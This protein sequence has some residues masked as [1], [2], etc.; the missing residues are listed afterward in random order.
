M[1]NENSIP[2]S[3]IPKG[4]TSLSESPVKKN[5]PNNSLNNT[6]KRVKDD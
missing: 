4:V 3:L 2:N 6:I 1:T 5:T